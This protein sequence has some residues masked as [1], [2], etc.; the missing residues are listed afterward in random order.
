MTSDTWRA[1][2]TRRRAGCPSSASA[3]TASTGCRRLRDSWSTAAELVVGGKRHLELAEVLIRGR[4]LAWPSPIGDALPEIQKHRGRPVAV[5]A[6]G[7]PFHYGVGDLLMRSVPAGGDALPAASLGLQPGGGAPR[8][9]A[10]G[11]LAGQPARPR[12]GG[13]R[14][15][16]AA[17][18]AHPGAVVGRRDAGEAR[19]VPDRARPGRLEAD[20]ARAH[21]RAARARARAR[22]RRL[23]SR[24][25]RCAQHHR[26]G[27]RRPPRTRQ[28]CLAPGLDDALFEHDGQLTKREVRAVTVSALAPRHGELLWDI[29]L[30]AGSIAIEWLLRHPSLKAIGI[31]ERRRARGPR[32]AQRRRV[33]HA[34]SADRAGRCARCA[35]R[36]ARARCRLHRRRTRPMPACSRR[37]G[38][39]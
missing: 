36:P 23:R 3:R 12:P 29:G 13:H 20:R 18:R 30:G 5:L 2:A 25:H 15:P 37:R 34:R 38:R 1:L 17:R 16:P 31:E 11:R 27:D 4:A 22:R 8:L 7:D 33:R 14:A 19:G 9:V 10:A 6:S 35:G 39:P 24:G 32:R 26:A 28:F 21:G